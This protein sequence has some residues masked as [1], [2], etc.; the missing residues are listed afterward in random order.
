MVERDI[1]L[2]KLAGGTLHFAHVSTAEA[3]EAI[4]GPRRKGLP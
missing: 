1:R 2:C 3:I 4:R